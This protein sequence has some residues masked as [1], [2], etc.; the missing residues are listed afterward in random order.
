MFKRFLSAFILTAFVINSVG[1]I[2]VN[3]QSALPTP[4]TMVNLSPAFK[5]AV[6][7]GLTVHQDNPF[8][9]DFIVDQGQ[10]NATTKAEADRLIRYFFTALAVPEKDTWVNLSPYEKNRI[11]PD[12]LG[13]TAMGRDL[14]AQDYVLKQLASSLIHPDSELGK[15]FWDKV[16][17]QAQAKFGPQVQI[18]V[19]TFN[20]VWI[21]AHRA[22]VYEHGQTAWIVDTQ[23]K[24][25]M[26]ED[27]LAAQ[28]NQP[29]APTNSHDVSSQIYKE[30]ILPQLEKEINEGENF[31]QLRQVFYSLVLAT[32]FKKN[33]KEAVLTQAI[34]DKNMVDGLTADKQSLSTETIYQ[35]YLQAYKKGAFNFIKE[36]QDQITKQPIARK[37]FSGG[38]AVSQ[39]LIQ[40]ATT[41]RAMTTDN[42]S[43]IKATATVGAPNAAM[44]IS[45][46]VMRTVTW[47]GQEYAGEELVTLKRTLIL[48]QQHIDLVLDRVNSRQR[49]YN[50][51]LDRSSYIAL[52]SLLK[53]GRFAREYNNRRGVSPMVLSSSVEEKE[54]PFQIAF[55]EGTTDEVM[56]DSIKALSVAIGEDI[57][58][59]NGVIAYNAV[60]A[61]YTAEFNWRGEIV[62]SETSIAEVID[63]L[64][65]FQ[66]MLLK[67]SSVNEDL[68]KEFNSTQ[69]FRDTNILK[70]YAPFLGKFIKLTTNGNKV[71]LKS[72]SPEENPFFLNMALRQ[73]YYE[74]LNLVDDDLRKALDILQSTQQGKKWD[75]FKEQMLQ[76]FRRAASKPEI[77]ML[78]G[79]ASLV[80]NGDTLRSLVSELRSALPY[81]GRINPILSRQG[82][83]LQF[84]DGKDQESIDY[85]EAITNSVSR[86]SLGVFRIN[87]KYWLKSKSNNV[88]QNRE[89]I[90][91]F[92]PSLRLFGDHF[93]PSNNVKMSYQNSIDLMLLAILNQEF[94][95][96]SGRVEITKTGQHQMTL[97]VTLPDGKIQHTYDE[98]D[99]PLDVVEAVYIKLEFRERGKL[100]QKSVQSILQ[101]SG[102]VRVFATANEAMTTEA[103]AELIKAKRAVVAKYQGNK[104]LPQE[105]G[106]LKSQARIKK[107]IEGIEKELEKEAGD[108]AMQVGPLTIEWGG[109]YYH[110]EKDIRAFI[111]R[112]ERTRNLFS[113]IEVEETT[114]GY[115]LPI[116]AGEEFT[117]KSSL[118]AS[119][120][121]LQI[122]RELEQNQ[123][124]VNET[125]I[126]MDGLT[127][128]LYLKNRKAQR[129]EIQ[130]VQK[131]VIG[132][133]NDSIK[134]FEDYLADN[135]K[136][137]TSHTINAVSGVSARRTAF[138]YVDQSFSIEVQK[139][140][141]GNPYNPIFI[142]SGKA[143]KPLPQGTSYVLVLNNYV[144]FIH[145]NRRA[146]KDNF[147][148]YEISPEG[149]HENQLAMR[150]IDKRTRRKGINFTNQSSLVLSQDGQVVVDGT[151]I[152]DILLDVL[153]RAMTPDRQSATGGID[154]QDTEAGLT[155]S[156][157]V[158]GGVKVTVDP[159]M[160]ERV[161]REGLKVIN[162]VIIN[163]T[164]MTAP[165]LRLLLGFATPKQDA[166][167]LAKI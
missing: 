131:R 12:S 8:V 101:N 16:Y 163:M 82:I 19:N 164:P 62:K 35:N 160:I 161:R 98:R 6:I 41:N 56:R 15:N 77:F 37:Y 166:A 76:G 119:G 113:Q 59:I 49:S 18:P 123:D 90:T 33:L 25:M 29:Q 97:N 2:P 58:G 92:A 26:E 38:W 75:S 28:K 114:G 11:I 23:L 78:N 10:G 34:A 48:F 151:D 140:E 51:L 112:L 84:L 129:E 127:V 80:S 85:I 122:R 146:D 32:W 120:Y 139:R 94:E 102:L 167:Q 87:G 95:I 152:T 54:Y 43:L 105:E 3:A 144:M 4:G 81:S 73:H 124:L 21:V 154:L 63:R 96:A 74:L 147:V 107:R 13:Q 79:T 70:K 65:A 165:D 57:R 158:N 68:V 130:R 91:N 60:Q 111:E 69:D 128:N 135:E 24:V 71:V 72:V 66:D 100:A 137:E 1:I 53:D 153:D 39:D 27:Y 93:I 42:G 125:S 121:G 83:Y 61:D 86:G 148:V 52:V 143:P 136:K 117:V 30:I 142:L 46:P 162:P 108:R 145:P 55:A 118:S 133:F 36:E 103:R 132:I 116:H 47:G 45:R 50:N 22:H 5:P 138:T 9:F 106:V 44:T 88:R 40:P 141:V 159:A 67:I 110:G 89:D 134:Q 99:N 104:I 17:K 157:D 150:E 156:R 149:V 7:R 109:I 31:A 20:K 126:S 155:V 64:A 115:K 14:L